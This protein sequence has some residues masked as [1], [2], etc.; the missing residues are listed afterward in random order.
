MAGAFAPIIASLRRIRGHQGTTVGR[1]C[2][3]GLTLG[4]S[5]DLDQGERLLRPLRRFGRPAA[6]LVQRKPYLAQQA[7]FDATSPH[8]WG[9]YLK[10]HYLPPLTD[11]AIDILASHAWRHSSAASCMLL[12][13][14]GGQ[15]ARLPA[16]TRPPAAAMPSTR[17]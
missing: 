17:S 10:S 3:A 8:G 6:D 9:Y 2:R 7:M 16:T 5:G 13:H 1:G 12:F 11:T 15:I 4:Y 14:L